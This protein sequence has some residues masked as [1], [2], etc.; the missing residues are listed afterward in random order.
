[1]KLHK[2]K[3]NLYGLGWLLAFSI[4]IIWNAKNWS[5]SRLTIHMYNIEDRDSEM[6]YFAD[7]I[8]HRIYYRT[9]KWDDLTINDDKITV[10]DYEIKSVHYLDCPLNCSHE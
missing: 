6:I 4:L 5:D 3:N 9:A 8:D 2:F 1:M 10:N 7:T